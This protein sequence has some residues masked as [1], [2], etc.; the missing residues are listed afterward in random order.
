MPHPTQKRTRQGRRNRAFENRLKP[1][2]L[3][4]CSKC[5]KSVLPHHACDFCGTYAGKQVLKVDQPVK[6]A[7]KAPK[8]EVKTAKPEAKSAPA[9]VADKA[10]AKVPVK[11]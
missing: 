7:K 10:P 6:Q 1:T 3:A 5:K 11:K 8:A 2:A 9:K 4:E